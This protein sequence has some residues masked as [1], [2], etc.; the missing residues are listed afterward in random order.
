[1]GSGVIRL[2]GMGQ[3]DSKASPRVGGAMRLSQGLQEQ[4]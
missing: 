3:M 2:P 1:M 4:D